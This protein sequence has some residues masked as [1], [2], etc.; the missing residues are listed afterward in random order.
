MRLKNQYGADRREHSRI[1]ALHEVLHNLGSNHDDRFG[2]VMHSAALAYVG[3]K[4]LPITGH[5]RRW[6]DRCR[7]G[8]DTRGWPL[9]EVI[10]DRPFK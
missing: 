8:R 2:N 10:V 5:T 6:V 3:G 4:Q 7:L 1:T 9:T